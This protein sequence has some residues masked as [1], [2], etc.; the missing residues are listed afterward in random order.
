MR[1]K[2]EKPERKEEMMKMSFALLW[3][4]GLASTAV[5][6]PTLLGVPSQ[7]IGIGEVVTITVSNSLGG[8]YAGWLEISTPTVVTFVGTPEFTPTGNPG[9][10]SQMKYW[11]QYGAWYEFSVVS[12]PPSPAVQAGD[13]ILVHV[14]GVG[15]GTTHLNLYDSD[16]VTL[17]DQRAVA[18]IPE[19]AT[20]VLL[21]LGGLLWQR[22][23]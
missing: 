4:A 21:G 8:S 17:R 5:A 20:I 9:G 2:S 6:D 12:F 19:P 16:G 18:V 10:T 7:P 14:V 3:V 13:H 11:P 22:R 15:E 23:K 1:E